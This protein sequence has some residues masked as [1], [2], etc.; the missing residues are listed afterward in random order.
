MH[1]ELDNMALTMIKKVTLA[2]T[3]QQVLDL[4]F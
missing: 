4:K 2:N 3:Y 1:I